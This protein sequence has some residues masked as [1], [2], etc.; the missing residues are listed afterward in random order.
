MLLTVAIPTY[1]RLSCLVETIDAVIP[2]LLEINA[3]EPG[4]VELL[5]CNNASTDGTTEYLITLKENYPFINLHNEEINIGIDGNIHNCALHSKG[6][7]VFSLS[8]DDIPESGI[9]F[10]IITNIKKFKEE[11]RNGLFIFLNGY[12]FSGEYANTLPKHNRIFKED[13]EDLVF[14]DK[15]SFVEH[16]GVWATFVSS[17]VYDREKWLV[18]AEDRRFI[19][20]DI[21]LSYVLYS[22]LRNC[23]KMI[24]LSNPLIAIRSQYSG[25]YKIIKAFCVEW[26]N[27][28]NNV[29]IVEWG[30]SKHT[31]RKIFKTSFYRNLINKVID[32][33]KSNSLVPNDEMSAVMVALQEYPLERILMKL[34]LS[35][36]YRVILLCKK[37]MT[38]CGVKTNN[39]MIGGK[40][41]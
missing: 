18:A 10:K 15:Q 13:V 17:F 3:K 30:Y 2:Q 20:T 22:M 24:I 26:S 29:S 41:G 34:F 6:K 23:S 19:G 40:N 39:F 1:N 37:I 32:V 7:Y 33:K 25:N 21:Y 9:I 38:I 11:N 12:V 5:I 4:L 8:D 14:N 28:L 35:A 27:L 16:V 36:N 31:N